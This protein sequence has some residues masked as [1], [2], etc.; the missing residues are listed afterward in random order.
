[1]HNSKLPASNS[2]SSQKNSNGTSLACS[3]MHML[4]ERMYCA[5]QMPDMCARKLKTTDFVKCLC[6]FQSLRHPVLQDHGALSVSEIKRRTCIR[7]G[8]SLFVPFGL[9]CGSGD[10]IA[11]CK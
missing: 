9:N 5:R 2:W 10:F 6:A 1:M 8:V 11:A 3:I 7:D 4:E